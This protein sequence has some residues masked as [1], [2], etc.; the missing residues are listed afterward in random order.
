MKPSFINSKSER[1]F[2][3]LDAFE[4]LD[5]YE[6]IYAGKYKLIGDGIPDD[7]PEGYILR[8]IFR[9]GTVQF[10]KTT[11]GLIACPVSPVKRNVYGYPVSGTP[12]L[13]GYTETISDVMKESDAPIFALPQALS[14]KIQRYC[15]MM[16]RAL[17]VLDQN[18]LA[19]SQ[20]VLIQGTQG[21]RINMMTME[22]TLKSAD[23]MVIPC[24]EGVATQAQVLDLNAQ[25]HT[26]NLLGVINAM[27]AKCLAGIGVKGSGADKASGITTTETE[28][29]A[30]QLEMTTYNELNALNQ[31]ADKVNAALGLN[32]R[33]ELG[34]GYTPSTADDPE[35]M[36]PDNTEEEG[37]AE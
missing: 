24:L 20:P 15:M 35:G 13:P 29:V 11:N 7:M 33:F 26:Q 12:I 22:S 21:G 8:C 28:Y 17:R 37:N 14:I 25:D 5:W 23:D 2:A 4:L 31:W 1:K 30:Q 9:H 16:E 36:Q 6:D 3:Y 10:K 19:M 32:I 27:D 34:E 18:V